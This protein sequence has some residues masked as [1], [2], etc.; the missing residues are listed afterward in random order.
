MGDGTRRALFSVS[1]YRVGQLRAHISELEEAVIDQQH[2]HERARAETQ[3]RHDAALDE[4]TQRM[5]AAEGKSALLTQQ[6]AAL[7]EA[8]QQ[9]KAERATALTALA[10]ATSR[11]EE[12][13]S[14]L[15]TAAAEAAAAAQ[16]AAAGGAARC[17]RA[18]KGA[19]WRAVT[20]GKSSALVGTTVL[21]LHDSVVIT[22][23][24]LVPGAAEPPAYAMWLYD[25]AAAGGCCPAED[26][27]VVELLAHSH[28]RL[29]CAP[30]DDADP[31][32][33]PTYT[34]ADAGV[35]RTAAAAAAPRLLTPY[36]D[37]SLEEGAAAAAAAALAARRAPRAHTLRVSVHR[38]QGVQGERPRPHHRRVGVAQHP[39]DGG[40]HR[41]VQGLQA[42]VERQF[43]E[44]ADGRRGRR[45]RV[46]AAGA[47][48]GMG[49]VRGPGHRGVRRRRGAAV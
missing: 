8:A 36:R 25:R 30:S 34:T 5:D 4:A 7:A 11:N 46:P 42:V 37:A 6:L 26:A 15:A 9:L 44:V 31:E 27:S 43:S 48:L 3:A 29:V 2:A 17:A 13:D 49:H 35:Y 47:D 39:R 10:A 24:E 22:V 18:A 12:L 45:A 20:W 33:P 41:E 23:A 14:A 16:A 19:A 38:V 1:S 40:V 21:Q 32:A 28:R